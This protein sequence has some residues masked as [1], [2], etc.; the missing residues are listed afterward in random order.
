M[1]NI[2]AILESYYPIV[3]AYLPRIFF[4]LLTL[5]VGFWF[6]KKLSKYIREALKRTG[7][8]PTVTRFLASVVSIG[9]KIL[10]LLSVASVFGVHTTSFIA[11]FSALAFSLGT[12][13]SGNI[14]HFAS[15]LMILIFRPYK[16]G[17]EITIQSFNGVVTDIQVFHTTILTTDN[18]KIVI[19]NGVITSGVITN[20]SHQGRIRVNISM[21]IADEADFGKAKALILEVAENCPICMKDPACKV[22]VNTFNRNGIEIYIRPWCEPVN[23]P[24]IHF[25][26]NE[27]VRNAFI[28]NGIP[29]PISTMDVTMR[30]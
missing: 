15:G 4:A 22:L 29:A 26:F 8:E 11:V 13:L 23:A 20:F 21:M 17:D 6:I 14:G 28:A 3:L 27:N 10:L 19:P 2:S 18:R 16:V 24:A 7:S 25:Y 12:A 30:N 9:L 5:V 1:F